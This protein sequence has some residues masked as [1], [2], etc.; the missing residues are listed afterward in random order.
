MIL[1]RETL[2]LKIKVTGRNDNVTSTG[3]RILL[4]GDDKENIQQ[5]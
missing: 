1:G 5:E 4:V 3:E 2:K